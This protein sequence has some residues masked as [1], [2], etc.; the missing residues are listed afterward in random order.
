MITCDASDLL[1]T[2]TIWGPKQTFRKLIQQKTKNKKDHNHE[3]PGRPWVRIYLSNHVYGVHTYSLSTIEWSPLAAVLLGT[4]PKWTNWNSGILKA[5]LSPSWGD[6]EAHNEIEKP[7]RRISK[8]CFV[9]LFSPTWNPF[10]SPYIQ[11]LF[12]SSLSS[13]YFSAR[14]KTPWTNNSYGGLPHRPER[15]RLPRGSGRSTEKKF[16]NVTP[17]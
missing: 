13:K 2:E 4:N 10:F 8:P 6:L 15:G 5:R 7:S 12:T 17:E 1:K 9:G 11:G 16:V 14:R 3:G